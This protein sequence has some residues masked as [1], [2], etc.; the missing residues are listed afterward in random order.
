[1]RF[2]TTATLLCG[3]AL[4]G[5]G[6]G[7]QD[8]NNN[9]SNQNNGNQHQA[10]CGDG[11]EEGTE[12]CDL[13][14]ANDD[15]VPDACRTDCRNAHCGDGVLDTTEAGDDGRKRRG[16][17]FGKLAIHE[18]ALRPVHQL[19]QGDLVMEIRGKLI[20]HKQCLIKRGEDLPGIRNR[21]CGAE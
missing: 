16:I 21:K 7:S 5:C 17:V 10:V 1:M 4:T 15:N 11:I 20:E 14:T 18:G 9:Q 12:E 3:V 8:V 13:G 19:R 6:D 2:L